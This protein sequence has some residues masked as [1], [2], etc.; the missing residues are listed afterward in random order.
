MVVHVRFKYTSGIYQVIRDILLSDIH[1]YIFLTF[2]LGVKMEA[3]TGFRVLIGKSGNSVACDRERLDALQSVVDGA[4]RKTAID[5]MVN[6]SKYLAVTRGDAVPDGAL[7]SFIRQ[8]IGMQY[9]IDAANSGGQAMDVIADNI[10]SEDTTLFTL[11]DYLR[12][13]TIVAIYDNKRAARN[14]LILHY[15]V[16]LND[17]RKDG[18]RWVY[19]AICLSDE[20]MYEHAEVTRGRQCGGKIKFSDLPAEVRQ[21]LSNIGYFI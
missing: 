15:T 13:C 21:T 11:L 1:K 12:T 9:A 4:A 6:P 7:W 18:D 5:V 17:R 20:G 3:I 16:I 2:L 8:N 14:G 10:V 19:T